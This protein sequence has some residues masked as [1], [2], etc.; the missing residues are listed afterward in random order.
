MSTGL[1]GKFPVNRAVTTGVPYALTLVLHNCIF[2]E[3]STHRFLIPLFLGGEEVR[4][5]LSKF[6]IHFE[7]LSCAGQ[8]KRE[9]AERTPTSAAS[10]RMPAAL[11]CLRN[12]FAYVGRTVSEFDSVRF[13]NSKSLDRFLTD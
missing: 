1:P 8:R 6:R 2:G 7:V 12:P 10:L 13:R 11:L 5:R 9:Q 3:A 4:N